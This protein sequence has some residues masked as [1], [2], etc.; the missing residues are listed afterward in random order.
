MNSKFGRI[1][2]HFGGDKT[3]S[4]AIQIALNLSRAELM[5]TGLVAYAPNQWHPELGSCFSSEPEKYIFN[6]L[7]G[8]SD[9][10]RI[11]ERDKDYF[12]TL[13]RWLESTPPCENLVFSYEGFVD[14][15]A[16]ALKGL[17]RFCERWANNILV[18]LYVRPPL[19]YAVSAM[20][21]RVKQGNF[22]WPKNDPPISSYKHFCEKI[23]NTF[24]TQEINVRAFD[25]QILI[26]GDVIEDFCQI[27]HLDGASV[28]LVL[29]HR[30]L[31]NESL[32]TSG[33]KLGEKIIENLHA[34][35]VY[36]DDVY[37]YEHI[38]KQI[39]NISGD[40]IT[41]TEQQITEVLESSAEH[42]DFL[43]NH[44]N[45]N[46]NENLDR[47]K[48]STTDLHTDLAVDISAVGSAVGSMLAKIFK[49][50]WHA[51]PD[52]NS[53]DFLL[54][55]VTLFESHRVERGQVICFELEFSLLI[56]IAELEI[57]IHIFDE[58]GRWAF[59][60]NTTLLEKK[61]INVK[62]GTHRVQY[63][64]VV[65]LTEGAY[66]AG[67][68]FAESGVAGVR[69]LAWFDRLVNFSVTV[70]RPQACVGYSSMP[71]AVSYWQVSESVK[72]LI[73][74]FSGRVTV[75]AAVADVMVDHTFNLPCL[76]H[77][78]SSQ[79]W[80]GSAANPLNLSYHWHDAHGEVVIFDG[81]RTP[82]AEAGLGAGEVVEVSLKVLA[83]AVPGKYRLT[84]TFVQ[85]GVC[86]FED[87]GFEPAVMEVHVVS[88]KQLG[89]TSIASV[90]QQS[91]VAFGTS[92]ARGLVSAMTD[93]VCY[94]Y[95]CGFLQHMASVGEFAPGM[96]V[97]LA[98]DLRPSSPRILSACCA[99]VSAQGGVPVFCGFVPSP[100]LALYAYGRGI[101]SLMVTGSHIPDDR[102]GI[103][104]NRAAGEVLKADELGIKAQQVFVPA[105][106]FE[107]SGALIAPP[108]LPAVL[109]V[110]AAYVQR[111]LAFVGAGALQGLRVGVYQHSSVGR[112]VLVTLLQAL[113][114]DVV[115]LGRSATFVPVDTE[116]VRP[117]DVLLARAWA[118]E[119]KLDAMVST[120]GDADR[121]LIA[122][123][124]GEWLRGD[125]LGVLCA[126]FLGAQCVATPVSSNTALEKSGWFTQTLRTRIGS[127][128]VIEAMQQALQRGD[129]GVCGYEANGGFLL[130]SAVQV[131]GRT[132]AP[133]PTRDAVLPMLAVLVASRTQGCAVSDLLSALPGRFTC[134]DRIQN[135]PTELS[136]ARLAA[137]QDGPMAQQL[138]AI[139]AL[140][141]Y[142]AGEVKSL[143]ATDGLRV[144]FANE[145][146][147]HLRPSGNAPELRCYTEA[148]SHDRAAELNASALK[149]LAGWRD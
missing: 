59:G 137:L 91:G 35:G 133:L 25:P 149:T 14:L 60:T 100:A 27:L 33:I 80:A 109:D 82:F 52:I 145:E 36:L 9:R 108:E 8:I 77:N 144:T 129:A 55:N 1:V 75:L 26:N 49:G 92:G 111:Y 117:E 99:A 5:A 15:D 141:G 54:V 142:I 38:G 37:F 107:A 41:L 120:D 110:T 96:S 45:I 98:G 124:R 29:Q 73:E 131:D 118:A 30:S 64:L 121:P 123:E 94:A 84:V 81:E 79:L 46:F 136:Q 10:R 135:F 70:P 139:E 89:G 13:E 146:V 56:N 104:F 57:G 22:S 61:L 72:G 23:L 51:K 87:R 31:A 90:M 134:S 44:F 101:P 48:K 32:S 86:W 17:K 43:R 2:L 68:A 62:R 20:S 69:E 16:E 74:D 19:S 97:A 6:Q 147:I 21:Q 127:P 78:A 53:D 122:D 40:K 4:T 65:D 58:Y 126:R 103:K 28:R 42:T 85:D 112:D 106:M 140:L 125:V 83:P 34:S 50:K 115:V 116:A 93:E 130:A 7:S 119:H 18:V 105:S 12:Q 143:D 138:Q 113:G 76:L 24:E 67:F 88:S 95:T 148:A 63:H 71:V 39:L 3:G 102:N 132:L 11:T 128:F 114:A 66:T 47:Y